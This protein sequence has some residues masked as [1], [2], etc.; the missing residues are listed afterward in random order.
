MGRILLSLEP[1]PQCSKKSA[2]ELKLK[3]KLLKCKRTIQIVTFNVRTLNRIGLIP[4]L[5]TID[6]NIVI[7]CSQEP[8]YIHSEDI[9]YHHTSN[10]WTFVSA[11]AG[12]NSANATI[13]GVGMLI[14]PWAVK[15]QNSIEKI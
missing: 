12:K 1:W 7:I 15:S 9:K 4:E 14:G 10:G 5:T 2:K 8:I 13:G 3:Q 11:S 6:H